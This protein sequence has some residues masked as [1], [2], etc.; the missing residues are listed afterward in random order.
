MAGRQDAFGRTALMYATINNN[1]CVV[2]RLV[3]H[4]CGLQANWGGTALMYAAL[5]G[6]TE[7][8]GLLL[9]HEGSVRDLFG[10]SVC[11]PALN[12]LH[13]DPRLRQQVVDL[14][15]AAGDTVRPDQ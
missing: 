14:L 13:T 8:C 9:P 5:Y 1:I 11:D 10:R 3:E 12:P 7:I 6:R 15:V 4:E 2:Q